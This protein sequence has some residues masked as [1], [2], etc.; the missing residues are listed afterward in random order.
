MWVL[1]TIFGHSR[2]DSD[3]G[4][5]TERSR[6]DQQPEQQQEQTREASNPNATNWRTAKATRDEAQA[7]DPTQTA[8][9]V[10]NQSTWAQHNTTLPQSFA[11][12]TQPRRSK[13]N[14]NT[15]DLDLANGARR[16]V[17]TP[18]TAGNIRVSSLYILWVLLSTNVLCVD[19]H[20]TT[21]PQMLTPTPH[22]QS[23]SNPPTTP[24]MYPSSYR[25]EMLNPT[26]GGN[27]PKPTTHHQ[28]STPRTATAPP[29]N[30]SPSP[31]THHHKTHKAVSK[32][33]CAHHPTNTANNKHQQSDKKLYKHLPPTMHH[34]PKLLLRSEK[35]HSRK[36][37]KHSPETSNQ[38]RTAPPNARPKRPKLPAH[39]PK[40]NTPPTP[41]NPPSHNLHPNPS[42]KQ[43]NNLAKTKWPHISLKHNAG[44]RRMPD[45]YT[46][47]P[48]HSCHLLPSHTAK[49]QL[50]PHHDPIRTHTQLD[51][52][53]LQTENSSLRSTQRQNPAISQRQDSPKTH[54]ILTQD[55]HQP[56]KTENPQHD[57]SHRRNLDSAHHPDPTE[58]HLQSPQDEHSRPKNVS[59]LPEYTDRRYQ[60]ATRSHP[61]QNY[62]ITILQTSQTTH[63][64]KHT[65]PPPTLLLK[66][67]HTSL[68][69][70]LIPLSSLL[71]PLSSP[72]NP[73]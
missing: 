34:R 72:L 21:L 60:P 56:Q 20:H 61:T 22:P 1:G 42:S 59:N 30:A 13:H 12:D 24:P 33:S 46:P 17:S 19:T 48:Y 27:P 32:I 11:D 57:S 6:E 49:G 39:T 55:H 3:I 58:T 40:S 36:P 69:P 4:A 73:I 5:M 2:M 26:S 43:N 41:P 25:Y 8:A 9:K 71:L 44:H 63:P 35:H 52:H 15:S 45:R 51:R 65:M 10:A 70:S 68:I 37:K 14:T 64:P 47:A 31:P 62:N 54:T 23:W 53:T 67:P 28:E 7:T 16:R 18:T 50:L 66:Y 29:E 38:P